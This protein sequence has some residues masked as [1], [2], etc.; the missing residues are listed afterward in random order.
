[1]L[2]GNKWKAAPLLC[3]V[4]LVLTDSHQRMTQVWML[5]KT[6]RLPRQLVM[7][8]LQTCTPSLKCTYTMY[9]AANMQ[10]LQKR[11]KTLRYIRT[12]LKYLKAVWAIAPSSYVW[13][14]SADTN[15]SPTSQLPVK[16]FLDWVQG[17]LT[18]TLYLGFLTC[19]CHRKSFTPLIPAL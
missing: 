19:V 16:R 12:F 17:V 7:K 1:M 4:T 9:S 13:A 8:E 11:G 10:T 15:H 6:N 14:L 18:I 2:K 3:S 5:E